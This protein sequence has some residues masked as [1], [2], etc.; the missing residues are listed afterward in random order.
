MRNLKKGYKSTYLQNRN[1]V[2]D[3]EKLMV[4]KA[5]RL[6]NGARVVNSEFM[7]SQ[8]RSAAEERTWGDAEAARS[9]LW[10]GE[11]GQWAARGGGAASVGGS[12]A[13]RM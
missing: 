5:D 11:S 1:R 8:R 6:G 7:P 2:T 3:F 10:R 12:G 13:G 4:T 9:A